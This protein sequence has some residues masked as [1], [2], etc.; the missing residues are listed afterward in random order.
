VRSLYRTRN[1]VPPH[2]MA[3][4]TKGRVLVTNWHVFEPQAVQIG[5][6]SARVP[7]AGVPLRVR[8]TVTIGDRPL[9]RGGN[10][11][12]LLMTLNARWRPGC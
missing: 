5:G 10:A 7:R 6:V 3:D 1:L 8:D 9:Q 4:L 11:T 2:L 12:S